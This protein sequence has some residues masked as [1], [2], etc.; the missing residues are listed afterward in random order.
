MVTTNKLL[1][2]VASLI[3]TALAAC[4]SAAFPNA[5]SVALG[6]DMTLRSLVQGANVC[7]QVTAA[8]ANARWVSIGLATS[9]RMVSSPISN[10]VVMEIGSGAPTVRLYELRGY[11]AASAVLQ[12]DQS[13]I[14]VV[15]SAVTNGIASFTFQRPLVS[16]SPLDVGLADNS[17]ANVIWAHGASAF[18][19]YHDAA[20]ATRVVLSS[21]TGPA[22]VLAAIST[23]VS[24]Y[25][26][27]IVAAGFAT[28]VLLGLVATHAGEWRVV[29][30]KT[31]CAPP[32]SRHLLAG[33]QQSLADLK[34]G[35]LVVLVV[36]VATLIAVGLSVR[37]QFA[38]ATL[39][40]ALSL[41]TGHLAL[42]DMMLLLLPV[43]R[44]KH[45]ELVFGISHERILKFHRGL[46]RSCIVYATLH[47]ILTA[48][49]SGV[50]SANAFGTQ[51]VTPLYG[52]LAFLAFASMG[53]VAFEPIRR[54]WYEAFLY[55]H[56]VAAVAGIVLAMLHSKAV[57]YGMIF[58]LVIY[59]LS[60]LGRLRA[61]F[62]RFE[63]HVDVSAPDTVTLL[64][65]STPQTK[66]WAETMN[67]CAFF[68]VCVPSISATEWHPF[69][70]I[71]SPDQDSIGFCIKAPK[72]GS[73]VDKVCLAATDATTMTVLVGGPYGKPAVDLGRY[74]HVVMV[75][76][77]IGVTPMLSVVN[78]CRDKGGESRRANLEMH[79][80]VRAP[81]DLLSAD[82]LMF[83]LPNDAVCKLYSTA[84]DNDSSLL[85]STGETVHYTR[86]KP[87]LDEVINLERFLGKKVCVLACGPPGLVADVQRHARSIN[88]DFHKEVFLF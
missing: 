25:T 72:K 52:F 18:P 20:G 43:A 44:G 49:T 17:A 31:L 77:G 60:A 26:A 34:L 46:G 42:V 45:W 79:W 12:A 53:L 82:R 85:S 10:A 38:D 13:S 84:A 33:F 14:S 62:N 35:E 23:V 55:F 27:Q 65:P 57:V 22:Q 15:R 67:P 47:L 29:N 76:G 69:S 71:V 37:A 2:G 86:G 1:L 16:P 83:P 30:Q 66:R 64:L 68:Y 21:S 4:D 48:G 75:C 28:M 5:P 58:P 78:Q 54:R 50:T 36:Y 40:R 74:D 9:S 32:T 39:G 24:S 8:V 80:V 61:F 56:R 7:F 51:R 63:A 41:I 19:S 87:I 88:V 70:A 73:F 11:T 3:S 81:T 6:P 59:G